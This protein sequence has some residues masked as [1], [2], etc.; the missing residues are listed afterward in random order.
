MKGKASYHFII[1]LAIRIIIPKLILVLHHIGL[2]KPILLITLSSLVLNISDV[3]IVRILILLTHIMRKNTSIV[4][5]WIWSVLLMIIRQIV[6]RSRLVHLMLILIKVVLLIRHTA[7]ILLT[8]LRL[9]FNIIYL[10][11]LA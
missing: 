8:L 4:V 6:L 11:C 5:I 1:N 10:P 7:I 9:S 2:R 3:R